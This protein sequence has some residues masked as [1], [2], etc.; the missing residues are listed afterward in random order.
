MMVTI[1][2]AARPRAY[3]P[4]MAQEQTP[5]KGKAKV[6]RIKGP[7]TS[8]VANL[9][10]VDGLPEGEVSNSA[11]VEKI[12]RV[13]VTIA[14]DGFVSHAPEGRKVFRWLTSDRAD[15]SRTVQEVGHLEEDATEQQAVTELLAET[16]RALE[17]T[18]RH[19]GHIDA[20]LE[21][22]RAVRAA[23]VV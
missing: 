9:F 21:Q 15:L 12:R 10:I 18:A 11:L 6:T 3:M 22:I 14:P 17:A 8:T 16:D 5:D 4:S 7:R 20:L 23:T 1:F 13:Y 19:A 2:E